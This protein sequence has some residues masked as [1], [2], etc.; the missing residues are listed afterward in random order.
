MA[1]PGHHRLNYVPRWCRVRNVRLVVSLAN[2]LFANNGPTG[3]QNTDQ[4]HSKLERSKYLM[5]PN[6]FQ[7]L[8]M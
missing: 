8:S 5:F 2:E 7:Q 3:A 6:G 4:I 1:R